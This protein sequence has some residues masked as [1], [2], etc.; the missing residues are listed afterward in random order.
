MLDGSPVKKEEIKKKAVEGE[1]ITNRM[2]PLEVYETPIGDNNLDQ[3]FENMQK[4]L[5]ENNLN[6]EMSQ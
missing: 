4:R 1:K 6:E 3:Y 5:R 2:T